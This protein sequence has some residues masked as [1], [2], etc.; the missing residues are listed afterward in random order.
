MKERKQR[1]M[2]I[3]LSAVL[4][5]VLVASGAVFFLLPSDTT[6]PPQ[7]SAPTANQDT[8]APSTS[9][10]FHTGVLERSVYQSLNTN[11]IET[12]LLP[13]RPPAATGKA[14]PFL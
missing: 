12:G 5:A 9:Q 10:G 6:E 8:N 2:I 11:L 1:T 14:N 4:L 13:V 3:M 7:P